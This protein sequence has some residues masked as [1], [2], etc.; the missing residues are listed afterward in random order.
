MCSIGPILSA[1][2]SRELTG[3]TID[4]LLYQSCGAKIIDFI[5]MGWWDA[6]FSAC[7]FV[8]GRCMSL[9]ER[10]GGVCCLQVEAI[11]CL[12]SS[13]HQDCGMIKDWLQISL[14]NA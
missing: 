8:S 11:F 10:M 12:T 14:C 2:Q 5:A 3:L 13:K 6:L 4:L 7:R 9:K 1:P